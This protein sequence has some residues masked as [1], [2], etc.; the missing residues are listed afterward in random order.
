MTDIQIYR[1]LHK[2]VDTHFYSLKKKNK[3][4]AYS[5]FIIVK[6][7]QFKVNEAGR[8]RVLNTK[9]KNVHAF[10]VCQEINFVMDDKTL[11]KKWTT[12]YGVP[13][14][15]IYNPYVSGEFLY[16]DGKPID[17]VSRLILNKNGLFSYE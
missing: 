4:F 11:E 12:C 13:R 1:N 2:S 6:D 8:Q 7:A 16:E 17:K 5:E 15:I 9:R 10:V 14:K 3:V